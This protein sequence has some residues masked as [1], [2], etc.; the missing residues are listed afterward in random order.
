MHEQWT[1]DVISVQRIADRLA[2]HGTALAEP[3]GQSTVWVGA[4]LRVH[5]R[6]DRPIFDISN[7][8]AYGGDLMVYGTR[9][10]GAYPGRN[11]WL[12]VRS[13]Q[14]QGNWVP[15]EGEALAA[16]LSELIAD[17]VD[18][19]DIRVISPF[20]DVVRGSKNLL[21]SIYGSTFADRNV[22]TVHTVQGQESDVI[23]LILGSAPRNDGARHG[24]PRNR[25]CSTWPHPAPNAAST[26]SATET[27]G[28][29]CHTSPYSPHPYP[30][31]RPDRTRS[32]SVR[33]CRPS[34]Q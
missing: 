12:D 25:T 6:C 5:R 3:D 28:K 26:S 24:R 16:L 21:R 15:A 4:P 32:L 29:T 31:C 7:T 8:I 20:R 2:R 9:V 34:T 10:D 30:S 19:T 11:G 33:A 22:G 14:S 13:G 18:P 23:V 27:T 1:P 17:G